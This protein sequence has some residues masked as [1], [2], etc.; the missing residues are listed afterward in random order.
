[1]RRGLRVFTGFLAV[2]KPETP[3]DAMPDSKLETLRL[4]K[5]PSVQE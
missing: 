3:P 2:V 1:M 5:T 4:G